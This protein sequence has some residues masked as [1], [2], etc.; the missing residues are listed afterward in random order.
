MEFHSVLMASCR[1]GGQRRIVG[2]AR[3]IG[4]ELRFWLRA[5]AAVR[6]RYRYCRLNVLLHREGRSVNFKLA[7]WIDSL[8]LKLQGT[9]TGGLN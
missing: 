7:Y 9:T 8:Y 4:G 6:M 5:L 1:S 3:R 2:P